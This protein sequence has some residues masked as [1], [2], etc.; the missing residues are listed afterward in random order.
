MIGDGSII[1]DGG[2]AALVIISSTCR[3]SALMDKVRDLAI[4]V[5]TMKASLL[6]DMDMT[7]PERSVDYD[8]EEALIWLCSTTGIHWPP[9]C[10]APSD[11]TNTPGAMVWGHP[12]P[13]AIR[14]A[15]LAN[16]P[17]KFAIFAYEKGERHDD[18]DRHWPSVWRSLPPTVWSCT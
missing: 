17:A 6:D 3:A 12:S 2:G 18:P 1:G 15:G 16:S 7:G 10:A 11:L 13:S 8:E 4:P 5:I 14:I 9:P